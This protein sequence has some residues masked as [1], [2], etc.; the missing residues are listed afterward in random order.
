MKTA[1]V[2]DWLVTYAGSER[3]LEQIL[4]LYPDADLYS[5]VDFLPPRERG[6]LQGRPVRTSCIQ[7]LPWAKSKYRSYLPFMP[8]AI[9]R[10][11][12]SGY[13]LV[14]SSSHAVAK[15][16]LTHAQQLHA[17]YCY[18]PMRYAWDLHHQYLRD[19]GLSTGVQGLIARMALHYLRLWDYASA[20]RVD[21]Y[22]AIS[23]YVGR[24]IKKVYHRDAAVVYPPVDV[25]FFVPG[26]RKED[27]FLTASRMVPY[28]KIDLIAEA[29]S[30]MPEKKLVVIGAGPDFNKVRTKAGGNVELLGYQPPDVMRDY[31]QR[32]QAFVYAADEDFGIVAV[33]AQ[34][35]GTP[36]IAFNR[37]G[38]RETVVPVL[39][40]ERG[41]RSEEARRPTGVFFDEQTAGS[42]VEAVRLFEANRDAFDPAA[43]RT[44]AERFSRE[45]FRTEFRAFIDSAVSGTPQVG[46][47]Q[48]A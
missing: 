13:D 19:S 17:C 36:V 23:Q 24:R 46:D 16:V 42:L 28:K 48:P 26:G 34:A 44:N 8:L 31:L 27:F 14:I 6:F 33:E 5:L 10:F 30:R 11:D 47:R 9:E 15:G 38:A 21:H 12:L 25:D 41:V 3:A 39:S 32:A 4:A 2:H 45:R 18:T 29:F 43:I 35:C 1:I 37:G 7:K 40:A 20:A 22:A